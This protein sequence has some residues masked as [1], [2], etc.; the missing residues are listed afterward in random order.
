MAIVA[1]WSVLNLTALVPSIDR[2]VTDLADVL[3]AQ[4]EEDIARELIHH[5]DATGVQLAVLI[6]DTT[7]G[8]DIADYAQAVFDRWGGGSKERNDGAL[9][10]LATSDRRSR[11]HLGYGL[12]PVIPDAM[13]KRMLDELRPALRDRDY[14]G[15]TLELVRGV[16]E[17]TEHLSPG[18]PIAPPLGALRWLWLVV[19]L[20][21]IGTGI[22]WA[23]AFRHAWRGYKSKP[24]GKDHKKKKWFVRIGLACVGLAR[25]RRL[26]LALG[27]VLLGQLLLWLVF[28][29]GYVGPYSL[30]Y[31]NFLIVGWLI[32]GTPKIVSIPV[33]VL[34]ILTF[35]ACVLIALSD[36]PSFADP[37]VLFGHVMAV[38]GIFWLANVVV[39]PGI[40]GG[41][42]GGGSYS[43]RS[44]SS[45][46]S[47]YSSSSYSGGGG[48][49][50]GGGASSSW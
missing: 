2:P 46:S 47:S 23:R 12:E 19:L 3:P 11:L 43:S 18:E 4:A 37:H 41:G 42:G 45:S 24:K 8:R 30:V 40:A 10:V 25:E 31:W 29:R 6:V 14:A 9:F 33:G 5:R 34:T 48:S 32:G 35:G 17:H 38:T 27:G 13:A 26:Q 22:A 16:R 44:Y 7:H 20:V 50:G 36:A 21:G 15:A 1:M 39:V 28:S 49:S